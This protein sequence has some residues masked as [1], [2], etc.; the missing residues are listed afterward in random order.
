VPVRYVICQIISPC[1]PLSV[2]RRT[3][4]ASGRNRVTNMDRGTSL[5]TKIS[6]RQQPETVPGKPLLNTDRTKGACCHTCPQNLRI[7]HLLVCDRWSTKWSW[8]AAVRWRKRAE[9]LSAFGS[10]SA[11]STSLENVTGQ[12]PTNDCNGVCYRQKQ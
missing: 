3:I 2:G 10:E 8:R 4:M 7:A 12:K 1:V 11:V 5:P 9:Y 6:G